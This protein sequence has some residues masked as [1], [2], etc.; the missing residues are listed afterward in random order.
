MGVLAIS[1]WLVPQDRLNSLIAKQLTSAFGYNVTVSGRPS[2]NFFPYLAVSFGPLKV[3]ASDEGDTPLMEIERANGRLS[4]TS[5]WEGQ[6]QLRYINLEKARVLLK[7]DGAGGSNWTAAQFFARDT[8][9]PSGAPVLRFPKHLRTIS[10]TDSVVMMIDPGL[11]APVEITALNATIAG[12]PRN[13]DFE[14]DGTF[15]WRGE[16]VLGTA[17]L[18]KPGV[19]MTGNVS[20]AVIEVSATPVTATFHGD[21]VW[22]EK[23]RADGALEATISSAPKLSKWIGMGGS[24]LLSKDEL[25]L[26]GDG[27]FTT[28][29]LSFRPIAIRYP[30]GKADGRFE[31]DISGKSLGMTGT[32]AFDHLTI[33]ETVNDEPGDH[34]FLDTLFT[35]DNANAH[36]DLRLSADT[37]SFAGHAVHDVAVGLFLKDGSF[38]MNI[39]SARFGENPTDASSKGN[40]G[41]EIVVDFSKTK[42]AISAN[43]TLSDTT[44]DVLEKS[45][46][47]DFPFEGDVSASLQANA[48][49]ANFRALEEALTL[50]VVANMNAGHMKG[51][52][53]QS[54]LNDSAKNV[55]QI[56]GDTLISPFE[57]GQ[58]T[59]EISPDGIVDVSDLSLE[60]ELYEVTAS[61]KLNIVQ[62]QLSMLGRIA[63]LSSKAK[64]EENVKP[65][66]QFT[67]GG[68]L[69]KPRISSIDGLV[70]SPLE[71]TQ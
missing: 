44:F 7:R 56:N 12:P 50:S 45:I 4:V 13:K 66:I 68:A 51:I 60:G 67:L 61:G 62:D 2:V 47:V 36:I 14:V 24:S 22:A 69:T 1:F 64:E 34:S 31:L 52:A 40:L 15:I 59:A 35:A 3:A 41:G 19:F 54:L 71:T 17:K 57:R 55:K 46:D 5:L 29:K 30:D 27:V 6:P 33:N 32:L 20:P 21:I 65:A 63:P 25:R 11:D 26:L 18:E 16:K 70:I 48:T 49:G 38:L 8:D 42:Q 58:F 9:N 53:F 23:L 43:L 39:G 10:F 28:E 37:G